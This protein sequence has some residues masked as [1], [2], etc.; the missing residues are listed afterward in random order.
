MNAWQF[1]HQTSIIGGRI[2]QGAGGISV[3]AEDAM[4]PKSVY[5]AEQVKDGISEPLANVVRLGLDEHNNI[6]VVI[7]DRPL[8]SVFDRLVLGVTGAAI[9]AFV[10]TAVQG[11]L[12]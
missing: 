4:S 2:Q 9:G 10:A 3:R 12:S 1:A 8:P 6:V 5:I 7:K 11:L